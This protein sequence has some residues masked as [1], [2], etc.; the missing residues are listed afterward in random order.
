MDLMQ[1][2][3]NL[4]YRQSKKRDEERERTINED[5]EDERCKRR[6]NSPLKWLIT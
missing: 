2:N 5:A 6:R 3:A 4:F 1:Y